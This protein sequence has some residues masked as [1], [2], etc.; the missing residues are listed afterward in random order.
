MR[1]LLTGATGFIGSAI[2]ARLQADGHEVIGV[3]RRAGPASQRVPVTRWLELDVARATRPEAWSRHLE[4][5]EAVVNCA[6]VLQDGGVDSTE[7]VHR[8]GPA[9][10]FA[11]CEAA[12]VRRVI[13]VSALGANPDAATAFLR[14]KGEGDRDLMARDLDW[15]VLRPPVV[16]GRSAYGG[17]ALFRALAALPVLPQVVDAGPLQVVQVYDLAE[18]VAVLLRPGAPAR[19]AL[20]VAG[21][22]PLPFEDM[23]AA[24]R[25]W[26]GFPPARRL[27]LRWLGPLLFRLGDLAGAL[28]WRP[29]LRTTARRVLA[30]GSVADPAAWTALTGVRPRS[31]ADALAAEPASVQERWFANL[32]LLKAAIFGILAAF[33]ILTGLITLGPAYAAGVGM[34]QAAGAGALAGPIAIGGGLADI[35]IGLGIAFRRTSRLA[36]WAA[37]A[38][39]GAYLVAGTLLAPGLW[40]EPLGPLTKIVPIMVLTVLAL[41]VQEDR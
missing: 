38:L 19:L 17:S 27:P 28:G 39:S 29:P 24:Y 26:L 13:Q 34:L 7:A 20:D 14:S 15:V 5:V 10:L 6:G 25:R 37:F 22:E 36:L 31:L 16:V 33:W 12:R 30:G 41:A 23:I 11:A 9:A 21:P 4:G 2:A 3:T 18:T 40:V 1:V 8:D 32:Y 35:A